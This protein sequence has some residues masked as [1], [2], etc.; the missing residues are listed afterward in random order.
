M[1]SGL[2]KWSFQQS[3]DNVATWNRTAVDSYPY[4]YA[5]DGVTILTTT[6]SLY[7]NIPEAMNPPVLFYYKLTNFYQNHRRYVK[8]FSSDQLKG[9]AVDNGTIS[10][11]ACEP[12]RLDP[13]GKA[14]YPCGIVANSVFN[15]TFS[16]PILLN[17]ANSNAAYE[18][19]SMNNSSNIAWDSDKALYGNTAYTPD[20]VAV[21][22]NWVKRYPGGYTAQNLFSPLVDEHF[23][24][25]MRTAGLPTF[26]KLS[27][28]N[29]TSAMK[30]GNYRVDVQSSTCTISYTVG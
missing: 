11:S 3:H 25:W 7:F 1:P 13:S 10:N 6:C 5:S 19:Y 21:P 30:S 9:V 26:S 22:P 17:P 2:V 8:S 18:E 28:R 29:D 27:Q 12:L 20:Q 14:Y 4:T 15:D 24:V 16:S 23:Q